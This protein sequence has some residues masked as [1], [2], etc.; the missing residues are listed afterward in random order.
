MRYVDPVLI[1]EAV[2][3]IRLARANV[4]A[5]EHPGETLELLDQ[6]LRRLAGDG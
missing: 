1:D 4:E 3:R 5:D 2:D 6:A